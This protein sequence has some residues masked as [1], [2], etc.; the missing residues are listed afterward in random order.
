MALMTH[1]TEEAINRSA[2]IL[3]KFIPGEALGP[4]EHDTIARV[5][6]DVLAE[7]SKIVL[8]NEEEIPN[9]YFETVCRLI[10]IY[11]ASDFSNT[12]RDEQGIFDHERRL[13]Y[14]VAQ[15]PTYEIL[16]SNYF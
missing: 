2:A 11:A 9:I 4:V 10:A 12:P 5:I 7:I 3:G 15:S 1:T 14:L 8:I 13:R 16:A 6:P